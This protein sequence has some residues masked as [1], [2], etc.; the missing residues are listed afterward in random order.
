MQKVLIIQG[1]LNPKSKTAIVA[2]EVEKILHRCDGIDCQTL[3]LRYFEIQFCDGRKLK[4]YGSDTQKAYD[5]VQESDGL[6]IGMPVYCYSVSGPL[7]NLIDITSSAMENKVAGIFC[8]TGS[9]MSY[10]ASADLAKILAY[11]SQVLSV[12]PVVCSSYEDFK[13]GKL[14][15]QK[16]QDKL[17]AMIE[18]LISLLKV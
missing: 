5:M 18:A 1:S 12:Q 6:I 14:D 16:V 4:D 15:S 2:Q 13:N 11:E 10:L 9:S 17:N 7:K 8:T 3:D